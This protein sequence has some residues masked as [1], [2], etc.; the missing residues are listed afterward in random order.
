MTRSAHVVIGVAIGAAVVYAL[1]LSASFLFLAR[2]HGDVAIDTSTVRMGPLVVGSDTPDVLASHVGLEVQLVT[3]LVTLA[4]IVVFVAI[5][6]WAWSNR[7]RSDFEAA[8][9]QP[10]EDE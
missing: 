5:C 7:R 6:A 1:G 10:L 9:R 3:G 2:H 4:L 8:A